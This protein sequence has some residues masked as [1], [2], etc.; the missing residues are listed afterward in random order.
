M[1]FLNIDLD[2]VGNNPRT[3][4]IVIAVTT[5]VCSIIALFAI[6]LWLHTSPSRI[7]IAE[8]PGTDGLS[9][10]AAGPAAEINL[11]GVFEKFDGTPSKVAGEWTAFRG[12]D[13]NNIAL[14]APRLADTWPGGAPKT[15]W[16]TPIG[17]GYAAPVVLGGCVYLMDYDM[18]KKADAIRCMSLDDGKEIWRRSYGINIKR[19]HGMSRTIP[20]VTK[21]YL[22]VMGPKCQVLCLDTATGDY[23]WG[24]DLQREY[25]TKEPLWY[26]GQ[27]PIIDDGKAIVAPAG[28]DVLMMALDCKTGAVVWKTPNPHEWNMSHSSI[29]KMTVAGKPMYVYGALGGMVGVSADPATAGK[30][31]WDIPWDAKVV[32][33]SPVKAGDDLIFATTGYGRGSRLLKLREENGAI[34]VDVVYDKGPEK[35]LACEQQ[36]PIFYNGLL[37]GI[38]PKD[39]GSLKGQLVCY[40]PDGTMVWTSGQ[41]NRFG[42]GPFML[43]DN[44]FYILDDEGTLTMADASKPE[45]TPLGKADLLKGHDAWGPLALA[46]SRLLVRDMNTLACV[47]L[48]AQS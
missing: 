36:T 10:S 29:I 48:G 18:K 17:D 32:A 46:G 5:A 8:L 4:G 9:K 44:K 37:Y 15:L 40:K 24:I 31:L 45:F 12:P 30:T 41:D 22:V 34:K 25:G 1:T 14:N 39:A 42:L 27:C 35:I 3:S 11:A 28:K 7:L 19:N 23:R 33:P 6:G 26:T 21:D 13:S 47:E 2:A 43:A 16:S 38:Q 20:A